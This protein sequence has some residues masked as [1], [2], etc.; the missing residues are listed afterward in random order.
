MEARCAR[1][2][3]RLRSHAATHHR[4][5]M[6]GVRSAHHQLAEQKLALVERLHAMEQTLGALRAELQRR[7]DDFQVDLGT[8]GFLLTTSFFPCLRPFV[9]TY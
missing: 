4:Y 1:G 6:D 5:I 3:C 2:D 9:L 8:T 7:E